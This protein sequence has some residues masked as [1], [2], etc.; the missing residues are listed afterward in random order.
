[1]KIN[2]L[3]LKGDILYTLIVHLEERTVMAHRLD[4][5]IETDLRNIDG[6]NVSGNTLNTCIILTFIKLFRYV[7]TAMQRILNGHL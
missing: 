3:K 1:M 5:S 7:L 4:K 2:S 6:N